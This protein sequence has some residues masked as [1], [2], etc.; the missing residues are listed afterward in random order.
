MTSNHAA[1]TA[2]ILVLVLSAGCR[3]KSEP[4]SAADAAPPAPAPSAPMNATPLPSASVN[5][6]VNPLGLPPYTGPTGSV[7]GTIW[8]EGPPAPDAP[9]QSY[10]ECPDGKAIYEKA[11]REGPPGADG[12]RPLADAVVAVTGYND[13]YIPERSEAATVKIEGC[14]LGPRTVAMTFGQR[15]DVKND[16]SQFWAPVLEQS[17][18]PALMIAAPHTPDPVHLYPPKPGWYALV[19]RMKHTYAKTDVYVL[20]QPLHSVSDLAG[21]YRVDGVPVGKLKVGAHVAAIG[22][23]MVD[24]E[25]LAGVVKTADIVLRYA[26]KAPDAGPSASP[27]TDGGRPPEI[28]H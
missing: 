16:T 6:V 7:E 26:P 20:L 19:D 23:A 10:T 24:V 25:V 17:S 3:G 15:L 27:R 11:F 5:K 12:R 2:A 18:T 21:H 28:I 1:V 22:D 4:T 14:A 9:V 8:V 13:A